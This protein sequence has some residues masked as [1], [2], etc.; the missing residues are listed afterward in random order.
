MSGAVT[1]P[2]AAITGLIGS[3][4]AGFGALE[5]SAKTMALASCAEALSHALERMDREV[6]ACSRSAGSK[7]HSRRTRTLA[8]TL[9]D[10][11]GP[12]AREFPVT[13]DADVPFARTARLMGMAGGSA[14][15]A[16]TVMN[17]L[18]RA[19]EAIA[20]DGR[21]A[22]R[23][24]FRDGMPP[25]ADSAAEKVLVEAEG[26]YVRMRDGSTAKVKA[27]VAYADKGRRGKKTLRSSP[28]RL[29]CVGEAP[30]DF[31]EQAVAHIGRRFDL[32]LVRRVRLGADGE[33][34]YVNG[35][36]AMR[37]PGASGHLGPFH[38]LR[39]VGRCA[40]AARRRAR[41]A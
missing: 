18:R 30:G 25:E 3:S 38:V 2:E 13:C 1:T 28:V 37:F 4:P 36:A 7:V 10:R 11:A 20:R 27:V 6:L 29:G 22:S 5:A 32:A 17:S 41:R 34:Q 35:L 14:V 24:L 33:A 26:T 15:S 12:A 31:W 40:P 8:T 9:G 23:D 19:G 21:A 16:T 39:A